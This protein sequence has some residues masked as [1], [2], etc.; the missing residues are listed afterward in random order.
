MSSIKTCDN[1]QVQ[2]ENKQILKKKYIENPK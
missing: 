1:F 2:Y